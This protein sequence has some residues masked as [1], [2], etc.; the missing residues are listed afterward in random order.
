MTHEKEIAAFARSMITSTIHMIL[1]SK[2]LSA[3]G[4]DRVF[5]RVLWD[6][7]TAIA[8]D[9]DTDRTENAFYADIAVFSRRCAYL[10]PR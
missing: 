9:Y 5:Y 7:R 1:P 6:D 8:I 3:R 10:S 2:P 4:S